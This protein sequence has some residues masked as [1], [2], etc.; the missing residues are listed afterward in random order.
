M[1]TCIKRVQEFCYLG[2]TSRNLFV[3]CSFLRNSNFLL[4]FDN[5]S[6]QAPGGH[7]WKSYLASGTEVWKTLR[8]LPGECDWRGGRVDCCSNWKLLFTSHF[9]DESHNN[10]QC[11][12][13]S[14]L[15]EGFYYLFDSTVQPECCDV[16]KF[17]KHQIINTF[18]VVLEIQY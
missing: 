7:T 6:L 16:C 3:L 1:C 17:Q 5:L 4:A 14:F 8:D 11:W 15:I 12:V 18:R 9:Q 2:E 10:V 13:L